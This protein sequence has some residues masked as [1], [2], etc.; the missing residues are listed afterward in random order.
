MTGSSCELF[1][2]FTAAGPADDA[3]WAELD[4]HAAGCATCRGKRALWIAIGEAA[5]S[6]RKSWPTPGLSAKIA[7]ALV[8]DAPGAGAAPRAAPLWA[9]WAAAA[10]V[11]ALVVLSMIGLRVFREGAGREPLAA[12]AGGSAPLLTEQALTEVETSESAYLASIDKLSRL[13]RPLLSGDAPLVAAYREKLLLLDSEIAEM[14]GEIER[15][16]FNT[17]LRRGL[18]AIYREKQRTLQDLM[19][20]S[21]S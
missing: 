9:R 10:A 21:S 7:R 18:L 6:L 15:N 2:R 16:R 1:D 12:R 4:A 13:A 17:H 11:A 19:K 14:R 5:P 3:A 20:G 8:E